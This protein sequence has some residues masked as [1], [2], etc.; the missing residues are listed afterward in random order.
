MGLVPAGY[1]PLERSVGSGACY[2][3]MSRSRLQDAVGGESYRKIS[4][5]VP[6]GSPTMT[7]GCV[8]RSL[9]GRGGKR[10]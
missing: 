5:G 4:R 6:S 2:Y 10:R 9:V 1:G 7:N 3:K 8:R